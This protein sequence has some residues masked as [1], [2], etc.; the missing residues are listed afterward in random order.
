MGSKNWLKSLW[1][2]PIIKRDNSAS[3]LPFA[4]R[5]VSPESWVH[6]NSPPVGIRHLCWKTKHKKL[7]CDSLQKF[8]AWRQLVR[9]V[10]WRSACLVCGYWKVQF[11]RPSVSKACVHTFADLMM[12]LWLLFCEIEQG[13]FHRLMSPTN[14]IT[15]EHGHIGPSSDDHA[16]VPSEAD[17]CPGVNTQHWT[18]TLATL[19]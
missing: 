10:T 8:T 9:P 2:W 13:S 11:L 7:K 18:Q 19:K 12:S 17:L 14:A 5:L 16:D 6:C 15:L 3:P 4:A 1:K